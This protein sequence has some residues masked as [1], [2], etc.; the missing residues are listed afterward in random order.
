[1]GLIL[2]EETLPT[3]A[4]T[5]AT[6]A[7]GG[8]TTE[9]ALSTDGVSNDWASASLGTV[10]AVAAGTWYRIRVELRHS[11]AIKVYCSEAVAAEGTDISVSVSGKYLCALTRIRQI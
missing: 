2:F 6:D 1:V 7:N 11:G 10:T 4:A 5:V 8:R 9:A 3:L